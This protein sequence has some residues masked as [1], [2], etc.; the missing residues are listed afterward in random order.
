MD[1]DDELDAFHARISPIRKKYGFDDPPPDTWRGDEQRISNY[2]KL[3][4][5]GSLFLAA[6]MLVAAYFLELKYVIAAGFGILIWGVGALDGRLYDLAVRSRRAVT[7][8]RR[9]ERVG[10]DGL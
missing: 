3:H 10:K 4:L 5:W 1:E 2:Y 7:F 8:L 6:V 9:L